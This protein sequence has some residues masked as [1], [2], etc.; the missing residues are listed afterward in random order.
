MVKINFE[1][2]ENE[3]RYWEPAVVCYIIGANPPIHVIDGYVKQIWKDLVVEKVGMVRK[4]VFIVKMNDTL[5]IDKACEMSDILLNKKPFI[6]KSWKVKISLEKEDLA[7]IPI[8]V[9][10]PAL[11]MEYW[12]ER[13]I[14]KIVGLLGN[15]IKV[16]N[17]TKNKDRLMYAR[18]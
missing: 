18:A 9:H 16:D 2:I 7:T 6:V 13:C 17:A 1:D 3:I 5:S 11:P 8:W 15:V 10:L 14:R 12:G 4:G